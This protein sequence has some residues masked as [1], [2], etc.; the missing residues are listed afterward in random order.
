[1]ENNDTLRELCIKQGY[2]PSKCKL[3][4]V[5]IMGLIQRGENPCWGCNHNRNECGGCPK[6]LLNPNEQE[7]FNQWEKEKKEL[8]K[9]EE[10]K[11]K[12]LNNKSN[13][14]IMDISTGREYRGYYTYISIKDRMEEKCYSIK[15]S[16]NLNECSKIAAMF[17][18]KFKIK[19][20]HIGVMGI[21]RNLY[22]CLLYNLEIH[23][24]DWC[25]VIGFTYKRLDFDTDI[26]SYSEES[27]NNE[28]FQFI[29]FS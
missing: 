4:G 22:D 19:E 15:L 6:K 17:I 12:R 8:L 27:N 5:L 10:R 29:N 7:Y 1:M 24:I 14:L 23:N 13:E 21:E 9:K 2:V 16:E 25:D 11:V 28:E 3:T 26:N 18:E 20:V